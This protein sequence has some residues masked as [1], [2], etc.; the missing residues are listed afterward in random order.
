M[1]VMKAILVISVAVGAVYSAFELDQLIANAKAWKEAGYS[2]A[3][4][5][6]VLPALTMLL[7]LVAVVLVME[8]L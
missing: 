8:F 1:E 3:A 6:R 4:P 7:S 5:N 2:N